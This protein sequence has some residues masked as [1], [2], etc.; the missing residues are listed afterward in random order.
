MAVGSQFNIDALIFSGSTFIKINTKSIATY[1]LN[2]TGL[3]GC[4]ACS[5]CTDR[6][7]L[8]LLPSAQALT[9]AVQWLETDLHHRAAARQRMAA[10]HARATR[11]RDRL[12]E[13]I[14]RVD[15]LLRD[16]RYFIDS[17]FS[18]FSDIIDTNDF[19][20]LV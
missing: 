2:D 4:P 6:P 7:S 18:V 10:D 8:S 15:H 5:C 17:D 14:V 16:P 11:I 20:V 19:D 13:K 9:Q 12:L 1:I 3:S